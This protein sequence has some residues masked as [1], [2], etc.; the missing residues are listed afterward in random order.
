L[1]T[2]ASRWPYW[3]GGH[4]QVRG[5]S[6]RS[7]Q[8]QIDPVIQLDLPILLGEPVPILYVKWRAPACRRSTRTY[9][10]GQARLRVHANQWDKEGLAVRDRGSTTYR[11]I[12]NAEQLQRLYREAWKRSWSRAERKLSSATAQNGS[13]ATRRRS[14]MIVPTAT[15]GLQP[16]MLECPSIPTALSCQMHL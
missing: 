9:Q 14:V 13:A 15:G 10:R 7:E 11:A 5:T 4:P 16:A 1:I 2:V 3:L 8:Q 6:G 12:E